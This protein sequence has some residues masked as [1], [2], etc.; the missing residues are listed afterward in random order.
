MHLIFDQQV[1]L[2]AVLP[3]SLPSHSVRPMPYGRKLFFAVSSSFLLLIVCVGA[4]R[5]A[6]T[7]LNPNELV[8]ETVQNALRVNRD[9][10]HWSYRELVRKDGRLE[11]REVV[12]TAGGTIDRLIAIDNQPLSLDQQK[13]ENA[14]IRALLA[15]PAEIRRDMQ[16]QREDAARQMRMFATFPNAFNYEYAGSE[17]GLVKLTF[18]PRPDFIPTSRQE[19]VFHHLEGTMWIDPQQKQLARID[20]R[21]IGEV[22]FGYGLLGHLDK[23]GVFSVRF[24]HLESGQWVM[25]ALHVEMSGRALLFKTISVQERRDFEDYRPVADTVT[26]SQAA[27]RLEKEATAFRQTAA[28][29]SKPE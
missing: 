21:L 25:A 7:P 29:T 14:R 20:G 27:E 3:T 5:P 15:D 11:T 18:Q 4:A 2:S 6:D 8:R 19:E 28:N 12:Q 23:D 16:K 22:R 13:R 17:D 26:L 1:T 9:A 10:V 24:T